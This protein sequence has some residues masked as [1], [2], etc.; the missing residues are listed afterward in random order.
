M[1]KAVWD[2]L[3]PVLSVRES[4][5]FPWWKVLSEQEQLLTEKLWFFFG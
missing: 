2:P 3:L 5:K 4:W 1:H